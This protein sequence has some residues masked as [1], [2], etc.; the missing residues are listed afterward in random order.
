M[1][2]YTHTHTHTQFGLG[3]LT[4]LQVKYY[5]YLRFLPNGRLVYAL[6]YIPPHEAVR[7]F[8]VMILFVPL[9][10][11]LRSSGCGDT[12]YYHLDPARVFPSTD[13]VSFLSPAPPDMTILKSTGGPPQGA[14]GGELLRAQGRCGVPGP[15][16]LRLHQLQARAPGLF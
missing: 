15:H 10:G 6:L 9:T 8:K 14:D 4:L 7:V 1:H 2:T 5:R 16:A 13:T 3:T 12:L 11:E